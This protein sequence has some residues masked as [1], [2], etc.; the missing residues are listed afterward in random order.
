MGGEAV[1]R[2]FAELSQATTSVPSALKVG[3]STVSVFMGFPHPPQP[4][5]SFPPHPHR[6]FLRICGA[7]SGHFEAR[8][9]WGCTV[10]TPE[11]GRS[12]GGGVDSAGA[13]RLSAPLRGPMFAPGHNEAFVDVGGHD[14][15]FEEGELP[16]LA[17]SSRRR[18]LLW[19]PLT[20][21]HQWLFLRLQIKRDG[22]CPGA[23]PSARHQCTPHYVIIH[24]RFPWWRGG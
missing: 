23:I 14:I 9:M 17:V 21:C 4:P 20:T 18:R 8:V 12:E 19:C 5:R 13:R 15:H 2:G 7:L 24:K 16:P 10:S 6:P 3:C 22:G 11:R 1:F